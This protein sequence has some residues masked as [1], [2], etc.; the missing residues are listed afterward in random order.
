MSW[1]AWETRWIS[2]NA[3]VKAA[4][5]IE[6][7]DTWRSKLPD[8]LIQQ[9]CDTVWHHGKHWNAMQA[10]SGSRVARNWQAELVWLC[11]VHADS[12]VV[13]M[14]FEGTFHFQPS[15]PEMTQVDVSLRDHFDSS[16]LLWSRC[17]LWVAPPCF[18]G[19]LLDPKSNCH[20]RCWIKINQSP[21][22]LE[23]RKGSGETSGAVR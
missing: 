14:D 22:V 5:R 8:F 4:A 20:Q 7:D 23:M 10:I 19:S 12:S 16:R 21:T 11:L 3:A 17:Q 18:C 1:L 15:F 6:D 13:N 9:A 2:G